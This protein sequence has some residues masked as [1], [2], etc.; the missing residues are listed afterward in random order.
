M[1]KQICGWLALATGSMLF[2]GGTGLEEMLS[3]AQVDLLDAKGTVVAQPLTARKNMKKVDNRMETRWATDCSQ[4]GYTVTKNTGTTVVQWKMKF[5][6]GISEGKYIVLNY[7][8][9]S[10]A[11]VSSL[12]N[13]PETFLLTTPAGSWECTVKNAL[14]PP[15]GK[16]DTLKFAW[17]YWPSFIN[18]VDLRLTFQRPGEGGKP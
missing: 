3:G 13:R 2:A 7:P 14:M 17:E 4:L 5:F 18:T 11:T 8:L 10:G 16:T 1:K 9:P 6:D 12:P 15:D